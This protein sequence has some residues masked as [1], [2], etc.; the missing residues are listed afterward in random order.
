MSQSSLVCLEPMTEIPLKVPPQRESL[1]CSGI[2]S[3]GAPQMSLCPPGG[4]DPTGLLGLK[5]AFRPGP[6]GLEWVL[7]LSTVTASEGPLLPTPSTATRTGLGCAL[8]TWSGLGGSEEQAQQGVQLP[9]WSGHGGQLSSAHPCSSRH[10]LLHPLPPQP[11][12]A[13]GVGEMAG[14]PAPQVAAEGALP[15]S[16]RPGARALLSASIWAGWW[17]W[18]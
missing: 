15:P 2:C 9:T 11:R 17:W 3:E 4:A 1:R 7:F 16:L 5:S 12:G 6:L 10:L 13:M 8:G 14:L 18:G